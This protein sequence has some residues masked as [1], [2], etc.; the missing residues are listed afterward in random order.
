MHAH[1]IWMLGG[2]RAMV[3]VHVLEVAT[4]QSFD[5]ERYLA[6]NADVAAAA[7]HKLFPSGWEHFDKHGRM[8]GRK[9]LRAGSLDAIA[10]QRKAKYRRLEPCLDEAFPKSIGDDLVVDALDE[11]LR[12]YVGA[13]PTL[14]VSSLSYD[15]EA[16]QIIEETRSGLVLDLGSGFRDVYVDNVVHHE[17]ARYPTTDVMGAGESLPFRSN[18]FDAVLCFAVLEHVKYPWLVAQE[19]CRVLKPGGRLAVNAPFLAPLHGYPGHY[20]NMSR[21]GLAAFFE[22]S[23]AI[24]KHFVP[25]S[26]GPIWA[27]HWMVYLWGM[28]LTGAAKEEFLKLTVAELMTPPAAFLSRPFVTELTLEKNFEIACGTYILGQKKPANNA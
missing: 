25:P 23:I 10:T 28:G 12:A 14:N 5:E 2:K 17:V 26:M 22:N 7:K 1:F 27:L 20:Y 9:I 16:W 4:D 13:Q 6:A 19:M 21:S 8:E 24:E 18:S 3:D 15:E 11:E